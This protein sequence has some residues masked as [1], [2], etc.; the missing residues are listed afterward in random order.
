M[1]TLPTG[2]TDKMWWEMCDFNMT[3]PVP[4]KEA[5]LSK[6]FIYERRWGVFYV[7]MGMH[8]GAMSLLLAFQHGLVCG[9]TVAEKLGLAYSEGTAD[10]W[11]EHTP[12]AAFLSSVGRN[13][14]AARYDSLNAR[15][16]RLFGDVRFVNNQGKR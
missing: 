9:I 13:I 16:H 6:P 10:Y 3:L 14:Q 5:D 1:Q 2:I 12:G 4:L 11:L 7:P 8:Q 15:E